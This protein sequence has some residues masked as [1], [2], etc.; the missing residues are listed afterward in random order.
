MAATPSFPRRACSRGAQQRG[1][2]PSAIEAYTQLALAAGA[3]LARPFEPKENPDADLDRKERRFSAACDGFDVH[4]AVCIAAGDDQGRERLVRSCTRPPFA[5]DRIEGLPDGRIAYW[6]KVPRR[7]RTP[8]VMTPMDFMARLASLLPPPKIPLL[9]YHGVFAP[10]SSGRALVTPKPPGRA[11][12]SKTCTALASASTKAPGPASLAPAS[13]APASPAPPAAV[14]PS[15]PAYALTPPPGLAP[16]PASLAQASAQPVVHVEPTV[17]TIAP[18]GR[19]LEGE[20]F[21]RARYVDWATLMKTSF[22]FDVLTCP[23]CSR[24]LRVLATLVEPATEKKILAHLGLPTEPPPRAR[25]RD[26]TGQQSFD[27]DAA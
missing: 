24:K 22:G 20:L 13:P 26:P 23:R 25:A 19:L 16:G 8:R 10:R 4:C 21:A 12:L 11:P 3:F 18:W 7:G 17:I 15:S 6:L 27:F 2:E 9:R 5:L 1:P 14:A